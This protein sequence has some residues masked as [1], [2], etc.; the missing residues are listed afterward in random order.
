MF[1]LAVL[2]F[3]LVVALSVLLDGWALSLLWGWFIVPTF[4]APELTL[5]PAIGLALVVRYLTTH[6]EQPE[7]DDPVENL[8][9][10]IVHAAVKPMMA[11]AIGWIVHSFM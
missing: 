1:L 8:I 2:G 9:R 4:N 11:L 10:A 5:A 6:F 7:D 3:F